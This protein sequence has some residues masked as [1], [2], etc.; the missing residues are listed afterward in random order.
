MWLGIVAAAAAIRFVD[1]GEPNLTIAESARAVDSFAVA[2]GDNPE[3]WVGDLGASITAYLF[4]IFGESELLAR[5]PSAIGGALLV[6]T[7]WLARPFAGRNG[8]LGAAALIALSPMFVLS[9]RSAEPFAL[10]ATVAVLAAIAL[11]AYLREPGPAPLFAFVLFAGLGVLTDATAVSAVL[12]LCLFLAFDGLLVG[13]TR[14]RAAWSNFR[15]SSLQWA[16]VAIIVTATLQLGLTH[17]GTST[18]NLGLP[19]I[20]LWSDLFETPRDSRAPEYHLALLLA[21]D[22]PILA[23]GI[24]GLSVLAL[25]IRNYGLSSL[26]PLERL[27]LVWVALAATVTAFTTQREAGQLLILLVPLAL[28]GG[29]LAERVL[30]T[31]DWSAG[32]G[33]W[34]LTALALTSAACAALMLTEWSAGNASVTEKVFA[35]VFASLAA[36]V[37]VAP[38]LLRARVGAVVLASFIVALGLTFA[39]HSSLTVSFE[40]GSEFARDET[41]SESREPFLETLAVL[42][43]ERSGAVVIDDSLDRTLGWTLRDSPYDFGGPLDDA[44]IF[45]GLAGETPD[46]FVPVAGE[47]QIAEGWYPEHLLKPL[48]LWN[49]LLFRDPYGETRHLI[50]QIYVPTI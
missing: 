50:V 20:A 5:L 47:W 49:W 35:V 40:N 13:N 6:A 16:I 14:V 41:L 39:V 27:L 12:A 32:P 17:F 37:A 44:S 18:D 22:W 45:V 23:A 4:D 15:R 46:G 31:F 26:G 2:G 42:A 10:G 7:L 38:L 34:A 36:A 30:R 8:A 25:R 3:T 21:Y 28:L 29:V 1:L 43:S 33:H 9:S 19:G 11:L 48:R 24:C